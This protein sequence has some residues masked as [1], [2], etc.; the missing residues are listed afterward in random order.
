MGAWV[1]VKCN[2][3][4]RHPMGDSPY[5][6]YACGHRDGGII[7]TSPYHLI[8]YG[9]DLVRIYKH[10]PEMFVVWRKICE[11]RSQSHKYGDL[12]LSPDEVL[13]WQLEIEQLQ[14][15]L[16]GEEFMGWDELQLWNKLR[17]EERLSYERANDEPPEVADVLAEGIAICRAS[18]ETGNPVEFWS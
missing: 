12:C 13:M 17:E 2:C 8:E 16:S 15:F 7:S 18:Q 1:L 6:D 4:N 11:W 9:R 3:P 10:R 14:H 5:G